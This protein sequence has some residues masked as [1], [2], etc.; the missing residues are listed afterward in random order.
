MLKMMFFS[1]NTAVY[2]ELGISELH[3]FLDYI[4]EKYQWEKDFF[5]PIDERLKNVLAEYTPQFYKEEWC[6]AFITWLKE[7]EVGDNLCLYDGW[8][9]KWEEMEILKQKY[10]DTFLNTKIKEDKK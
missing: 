3:N 4:I 7:L 8:V 1:T 9:S 2:F 5:N 10:K 6:E